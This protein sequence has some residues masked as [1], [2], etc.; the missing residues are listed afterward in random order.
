MSAN[1]ESWNLLRRHRTVNRCWECRSCVSIIEPHIFG[2]LHAP[3]HRRT[4]IQHICTHTLPKPRR[5]LSK[6]LLLFISISSCCYFYGFSSVCIKI[7]YIMEPPDAPRVQ[8]SEFNRL[9]VRVTIILGHRK[10]ELQT[11]LRSKVTWL[12][13][14]NMVEG[15]I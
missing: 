8:S 9:G 12:S 1:P 11:G 4:C 3:V 5:F 2:R 10:R 6:P 7:F 15:E 13:V 14:T